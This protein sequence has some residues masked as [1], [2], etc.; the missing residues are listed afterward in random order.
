MNSISQLGRA[1]PKQKNVGL[2]AF[3]LAAVGIPWALWTFFT[4]IHDGSSEAIAFNAAAGWFVLFA[5]VFLGLHGVGE[6]GWC[7]IPALLTFR[8]LLSF[9][10]LPAWRFATG[11]DQMDDIYAQAMLLVV[12][13]YVA[14]WSGSLLLMKRTRLQ[15]VPSPGTT[16]SRVVFAVA[17]TFLIGLATKYLTWRAG[18]LSYMATSSA[19]ESAA[20]ALEW[21]SYLGNLLPLS[22]AISAV[23]V[24]G[25]RS[26]NLLVRVLFIVSASFTL[27]FGAISG[28]KQQLLQPLILLA[29]IYG[30]TRRRI[31]RSAFLLPVLLVV[32][33]P[34][35]DAYR[36]NLENGYRYEANTFDGLK[37]VLSKTLDDVV[38]SRRLAS[39]KSQNSLDH[40]VSRLSVLDDV[41]DLL[42]LPAPSLLNGDEK[43]WLA[44]VYPFI[45]RFLWDE[46]PVLNKCQRFSVALGRP[47]TTTSAVTPIGDLYSLYGYAGVLI[48]SFIWGIVLQLF[49]NRM[50]RTFLTERGLLIYLL[51]LVPLINIEADATLLVAGAVQTV[52]FAVI[53]SYLIYGRRPPARAEPGKQRHGISLSYPS[54]N[55]L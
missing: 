13:A 36:V 5:V 31:P 19:R 25:R 52:V 44:P 16:S 11:A 18:L 29:V 24:F 20:P 34:F 48:G 30:I 38:F 46:K 50:T 51:S 43:L 32:I 15:Y 37:A 9:V 12:L 40:S 53:L 55:E 2:V 17:I 27:F 42:G 45:P 6:L 22:M 35:Y 4:A 14:L 47:I 49:M 1:I 33:Y 8:G 21:I 54:I 28:M 26:K 39:G 23:E 7:A 3:T 10:A 41:H